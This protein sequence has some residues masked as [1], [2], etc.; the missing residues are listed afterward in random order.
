MAPDSLTSMTMTSGLMAGGGWFLLSWGRA[1][2]TPFCAVGV[3][4]M[5]MM[6][7][8]SITSMS[9]VM[10]MSETDSGPSA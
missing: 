3:T 10:L 7:S 2:S 5:K 4:S 1:I 9:G 6:S 8:T